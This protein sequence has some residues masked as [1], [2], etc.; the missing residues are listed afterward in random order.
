M[1][2]Q[3]GL[4]VLALT[5]AGLQRHAKGANPDF[6]TGYLLHD[7]GEWQ[8]I[9]DMPCQGIQWNLY[10]ILLERFGVN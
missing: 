10:R 4:N 2:Y 5:H 9:M 3:R 1:G 7:G 6:A 8:K